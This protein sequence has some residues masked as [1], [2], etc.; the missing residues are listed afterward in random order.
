MTR[1]PSELMGPDD[2]DAEEGAAFDDGTP[3]EAS[4]SSRSHS[5]RLSEVSSSVA[6][7]HLPESESPEVVPQM[8]SPATSRA[9]LSVVT[10]ADLL[11]DPSEMAL[12][13]VSSSSWQGQANGYSAAPMS[14]EEFALFLRSQGNAPA[15]ETRGR[16]LQLPR[17]VVGKDLSCEDLASTEAASSGSIT[18][19]HS[20]PIEPVP[21]RAVTVDDLGLGFGLTPL[22]GGASGVAWLP[23]NLQ[24]HTWRGSTSPE[25]SVPASGP[26]AEA[27]ARFWQVAQ[28]ATAATFQAD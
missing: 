2:V 21:N 23:T 26:G 19:G 16:T 12:Q 25:G 27:K 6:S 22:P 3:S 28:T 14:P 5:R 18:T 13:A 24:Q 11:D 8:F 1:L 4:F 17:A 10:W 15:D 9:I 20:S 7:L